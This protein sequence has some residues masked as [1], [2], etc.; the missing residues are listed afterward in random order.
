M[1]PLHHHFELWVGCEWKVVLVFWAGALVCA[2]L[3]LL[4]ICLH[5][6]REGRETLVQPCDRRAKL[7][8]VTLN[9]SGQ[10]ET[11]LSV[12]ANAT[13]AGHG[14]PSVPVAKDGEK[15]PCRRAGGT[16]PK[17]D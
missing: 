6:E 4:L 15:G 12:S 9:A 2:I 1:T 3:G 8:L 17:Q 11:R 5:W 7:R 10:G 16:R 14:R 13:S